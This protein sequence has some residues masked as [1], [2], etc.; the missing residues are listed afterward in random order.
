MQALAG[1]QVYIVP[2]MVDNGSFPLCSDELRKF[3]F[4]LKRMTNWLMGLLEKQDSC[5]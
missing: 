5:L 4:S 3:K 2:V 1:T